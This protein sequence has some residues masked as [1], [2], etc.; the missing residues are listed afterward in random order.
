[1]ILSDAEIL[2]ARAR[3]EIVIDPFD[4]NQL[5]GNSYDVRMGPVL[6]VYETSSTAGSA[7]AFRGAHEVGIELMALADRN[8]IGTQLSILDAAKEPRTVDISILES[9]IVL[10][11][12]ILYLASTVEY[13]ETHEHVVYLDGK[14]SIGRLGI[15][16]HLTAGRGDV[17]FV[18]HFTLEMSVVQ[19]VRVY[20]GMPIGQLT[21]H[22]VHGA[23]ERRYQ[24]KPGASYLDGRDPMPQPSRLWKKLQGAHGDRERCPGSGLV[25]GPSGC[26]RA[27]GRLPDG[28]PTL[29]PEHTRKVAL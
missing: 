3:G 29:M 18:G 1:M 2:A 10:V 26:C 19:P 6:R 20:A 27:C 13:T 9:G 11:P 7:M 15:A 21:Y 8:W 28:N 14:S 22:T 5:G 17:G 23:V 24:T 4:V 16:V 12:G 25:T